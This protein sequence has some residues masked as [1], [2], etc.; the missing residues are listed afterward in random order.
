[1][2]KQAFLEALN[3]KT[4]SL[5]EQDKARLLEYFAEMIDDR[6]EDGV[7]EEEAVA[8]MGDP[9]DIARE[10]STDATASAPQAAAEAVTAL[11]QLRIRVLNA[12]VNIVREPLSGG[13]AAQL[14]FSDPGRFEWRADGE[15]LEITEK[16][17]TSP[18]KLGFSFNSLKRL[19]TS[20]GLRLTV[21][22][23]E[24]LP[25]DLEFHSAG[26]DLTIRAVALGGAARLHS[27]NGD[28]D[29]RQ[30]RC[31]GRLEI[32]T[33]SGDLELNGLT[34]EAFS[35]KAANGDIEAASLS[36]DGQL[37]LETTSGDVELRALRCGELSVSCAS[38]D[39]EVDRGAAGDTTVHTV[40]GDVRLDELESDP[41]LAVQTVS[42]DIDLT[43]CI[44]RQAQLH[45]VSGDVTLRLEPLPC[46][47][48]IVANTR[49][50]E[51]DLPRNNPEPADRDAQP[52]VEI[53]TVSGDIDTAIL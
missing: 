35:F 25:G 2:N 33:Q 18:L 8:A 44:A 1:M 3:E 9:A 37:C 17:V 45:S 4:A 28:F 32:N 50:G 51:I 27:A 16:D 31:A 15:T 46:G 42:G 47:Y 36:V 20:D 34:A 23:S 14:R 41:R 12:D 22:L 5:P 6:I 49:S 29:I 7:S 39:V 38:G 43:R 30:V 21:A 10:F 11:R 48:D 40:S 19:L 24:G 52:R 53:S 13:A 26:G